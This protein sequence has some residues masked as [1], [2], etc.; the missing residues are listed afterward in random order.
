VISIEGLTYAV[1]GGREVLRDVWLDVPEGKTV[2]VMGMS[3]TGKTS[4]LRCIAGLVQPVA[5]K[6]WIMGRQVVGLSEREW[7]SVR[8][9]IGY[10]FQYAALFDSLTVFENVAF[11]PRR[12]G[13][14]DTKELSRLVSEKLAMVG[15]DG[16]QSLY[17][18]ELSG[19]MK[20]RVGLARAL[21]LNPKLLLYDEPTSGL[22][23]ITAGV[24]D[25]LIAE[26]RDRLGVT[27]VVV[28][29]DVDGVFRVS[30]V[31][32]ML[33]EGRVIFTGTP[34][35]ARSTD[36]PYVRQ[37]IEGQAKGPISVT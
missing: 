1:P 36:N 10:V 27:S 28:S 13:I 20:K 16:T 37:F 4:L 35:E 2:G 18:S 29:H 3:G 34:D 32:A 9:H 25:D 21:A 6:I 14:R 17:P 8:E 22:D 5:G 15:L 11:G 31:V 19:G 7:A 33:Y 24:I 12:Q 26:M 23:P 30:D